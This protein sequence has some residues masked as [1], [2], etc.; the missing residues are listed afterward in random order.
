ML[1]TAYRRM[2]PPVQRWYC[3]LE[4][5][6]QRTWEE[7]KRILF[8]R[9]P[10]EEARPVDDF[11]L[12]VRQQNEDFY[13]FVQEKRF[14]WEEVGLASDFAD[15]RANVCRSS[16]SIPFSN[17]V[18]IANPTN[19]SELVGLARSFREETTKNRHYEQ[20][21]P[22]STP[23][24][25]PSTSFAKPSRDNATSRLPRLCFG[26]GA[27][28]HLRAVCPSPKG[29]LHVQAIATADPFRTAVHL[30]F[31]EISATLDTGADVNG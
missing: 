5:N 9:F 3:A 10:P 8:E 11:Y 1:Q 17:A 28:G 20:Q 18:T 14:L 22:P 15:F 16:N 7:F 29:A 26:C 12:R 30:S 6:E 19:F 27:A 2:P 4:G 31:G 24:N 23:F 21:G 13:T 25:R